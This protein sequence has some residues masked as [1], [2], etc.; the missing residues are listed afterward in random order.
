MP[1]QSFALR[2]APGYYKLSKKMKDIGITA[3][4]PSGQLL[5]NLGDGVATDFLK[6]HSLE[7]SSGSA[8]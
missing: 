4:Q 8:K 2:W 3:P 6:L 7:P 1:L 5:S